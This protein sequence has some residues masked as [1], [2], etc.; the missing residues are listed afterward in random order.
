MPDQLYLS[1][2]LRAFTAENMLRQFDEVLQI[3]PFSRLRPG[4]ASLK[5][6][7]LEYAEPPVF[8][9]AFSAETDAAT[10]IGMLREFDHADCAYIVEGR[11]EIW[12]YNNGWKLTP[13]RVSLT[14]F[15]PLFENDERDHVRIE[16][17]PETNYLPHPRLPDSARAV[18]S[19][20]RGLLRF[21]EE[22]EE[23]L[24]VERKSLWSELE[25]NFAE[26]LE[27]ALAEAEM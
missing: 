21:L 24:P 18:Q 6:Y 26:R 4:V 14:C 13:A 16:F 11:W 1:L 12:K 2:W 25:E 7:A 23:A 9:H 5:V 15:G 19:N 3:F 8:E 20:L 10:V 27:A 17:G 22:L